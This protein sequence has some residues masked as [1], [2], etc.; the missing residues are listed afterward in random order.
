MPVIGLA[1]SL[2]WLDESQYK[3]SSIAS[4]DMLARY[5]NIDYVE[6]DDIIAYLSNHYFKNE[7]TICS[8]DKDFLQLVNDR[9]SVYALTKKKLYTPEMVK[10]EYGVTPQNLIFYR[11]LMGDK[12][13]NISGCFKKCGPKT[14]LNLAL[15]PQQLLEKLTKDPNA[16]QIFEKNK[17]LT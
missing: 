14:A 13:D 4:V 3:E 12:S 8:S 6:A 2:N 7:V 1:Q 11:C 16:K 9:V 15:N 5:H 10:E 17:K